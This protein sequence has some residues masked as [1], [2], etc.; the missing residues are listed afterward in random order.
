MHEAGLVDDEPG[1]FTAMIG[2]E[3]PFVPGGN[4]LHRNVLYRDGKAKADQVSPFSSW[5]SEDPEELRT[6]MDGHANEGRRHCWSSPIWYEMSRR[7]F[8]GVPG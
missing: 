8:A 7:W 2:Y 4:S 1:K 5:Q 3:W 6:W